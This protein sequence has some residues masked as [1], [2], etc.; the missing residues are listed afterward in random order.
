MD[1]VRA[2]A[3][4]LEHQRLAPGRRQRGIRTVTQDGP[5]MAIGNNQSLALGEDFGVEFGRL[6]E[7]EFIGEFPIFR[8]FAIDLK[9]DRRPLARGTSA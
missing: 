7:E 1:A 3:G 4:Q 6:G 5:V 8:P 9:V 2:H